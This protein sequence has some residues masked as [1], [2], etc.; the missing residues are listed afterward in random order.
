MPYRAATHQPL[1]RTVPVHVAPE[2]KPYTAAQRGYG[3][4]WQRARAGW[5]AVHPLCAM[6]ERAGRITAA[7]VVDHI[8]PHRMAWALASGDADAIAAARARFWDRDNWQSLCK[9]HHDSTKQAA[10]RAAQR[11]GAGQKFRPSGS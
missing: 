4:R 1:R 11:R 6:C 5:L 7:D 8:V 9:A 2:A 10:E 3:S